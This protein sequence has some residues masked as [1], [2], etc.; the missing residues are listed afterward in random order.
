MRQETSTRD[1]FVKAMP[2]E[3]GEVAS[4]E[5]AMFMAMSWNVCVRVKSASSRVCLLQSAGSCDMRMALRRENR[6]RAFVFLGGV[7]GD[8]CVRGTVSEA[9][10]MGAGTVMRRVSSAPVSS[11][12]N[13][14]VCI[15]QCCLLSR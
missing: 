8:L 4:G 6:L 1:A 15:V 3:R 7:S 14:C 13:A 9:K 11:I 5:D 10:S 12:A 2:C